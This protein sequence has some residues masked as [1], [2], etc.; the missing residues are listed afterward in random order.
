MS[1]ELS[2]DGSWKNIDG[3]QDGDECDIRLVVFRSVRCR[4][5]PQGWMIDNENNGRWLWQIFNSIKQSKDLLATYIENY[6]A[7]FFNY[8]SDDI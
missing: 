8:L 2:Y 4:C 5:R 6:L 3:F 7:T 1:R